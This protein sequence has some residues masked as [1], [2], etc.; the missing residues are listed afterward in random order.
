M[1]TIGLFSMLL[2][3]KT[4]TAVCLTSAEVVEIVVEVETSAVEVS[5]TADVVVSKQVKFSHGHPPLQFF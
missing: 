2:V 1:T 4:K 3:L 5:T